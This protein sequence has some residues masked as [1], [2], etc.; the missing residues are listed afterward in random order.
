M[1]LSLSETARIVKGRAAGADV[2]FS[3]VSID[4]RSMRR[5]DLFIAIRGEKFDAHD[6]LETAASQG[7]AA[8]MVCRESALD[9][10]K[11]TVE[12]TRIALGDLAR[13]WRKRF[14]IP[15]IG[16][17]GSNGKTTV[18]EM[19]AA[20][21]AVEGEVLSTRGNLNNDIGVPLTLLRLNEQ[22]RYAVIEMGAN[23]SGEIAHTASLAL[24]DVAIITNAGPAH[25][26][27]FGDLEGVARAKGELVE[28]LAES[29]VAILNVDDRFFEFWRKRAGNKRV[30]GFG[31]DGSAEVRATDLEMNWTPDGFSNR[32]TL[33]YAGTGT[34]ITLRLA[35][36]H[37]VC[38][39]LAAA[40]AALAL[41]IDAE[42]I[43]QGLE[44]VL[45]V[46]GRMQ[47]L[48]GLCGSLLFD[49]SYNANPSSFA[50]A[51]DVLSQLR[52]EL[53]VILGAFAELGESSPALHREVGRY[54]KMNGIARLLATGLDAV[55]AVEAF[56]EGGIFFD[57]QQ[58]LIDA[59]KSMLNS[60][61]IALVK[62]SRSQK[63]ERVIEELRFEGLE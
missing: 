1:K 6:F 57:S 29:G 27:G 24:P 63:M 45:P 42:P 9:L 41:G 58:E 19:V 5:G 48:A 14:G 59:S 54:A 39:A 34:P 21:L 51:V 35:G 33:N 17:T 28:K 3:S 61:V 40:G 11:I 43:K 52:G 46:K 53:W 44:G 25:L 8:L 16:V 23:H 15:V 36:R 50:A 12:D 32:F 38:N 30:L 31:L 37:N 10:P 26:E 56:G 7:A 4:T 49:D 13:E 60:H 62:G 55:G 18:K 47:P 20:I 22:H 2:S